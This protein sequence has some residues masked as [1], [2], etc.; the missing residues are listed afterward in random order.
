[1]T[2]PDKLYTSFVSACIGQAQIWHKWPHILLLQAAQNTPECHRGILQVERRWA[3]L[4]WQWA[5]GAICT[6]GNTKNIHAAQHGFQRNKTWHCPERSRRCGPGAARK[7]G[8]TQSSLSHRCWSQECLDLLTCYQNWATR[9]MAGLWDGTQ[10]LD[11]TSIDC[12]V[13]VRHLVCEVFVVVVHCAFE[14]YAN[15]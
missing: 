8:Q 6:W 4:E 7:E 1:M 14:T 11:R 3:V 9:D 12:S 2:L 10:H 13:G 15:V 5:E